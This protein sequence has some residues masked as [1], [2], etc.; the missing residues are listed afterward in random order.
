MERYLDLWQ[1]VRGFRFDLYDLLSSLV[2]ARV[3]APCS[4]RA[5]FHDVLPQLFEVQDISYDQVLECCEF[6]GSEYS[7]FA[8]LFAALTE[9]K[10]GTRTE[11]TY[12][13]CTNF[14]FEIDRED[15]FRRKEPS[16]EMR[17]DP[18]VGLGLLLDADMIPIGMKMY[19]GNQS[20]KPV[21]RE[22]IA[23]LKGKNRIKGR[24]IHV[25]DKGLNCAENITRARKAGWVSA[26]C[27]S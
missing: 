12:F 16:K 10:Y 5:T 7:R 26:T 15:G 13:D 24:T 4:K 17:K 22:I 9:K 25:A 11:T 14:Y 3:I 27:C 23:E 2:F 21:L 8:E 19:P 20:E 6:I 18:I 1:G